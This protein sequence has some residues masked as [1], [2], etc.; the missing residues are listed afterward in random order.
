MV[1][2]S[3]RR[4]TTGAALGI[5]AALGVALLVVLAGAA[6]EAKEKKKEK[7]K[8][9]TVDEVMHKK[10]TGAM[11]H[12]QAEDYGA[13]AEILNPLAKRSEKLNPYERALVFQ[14]LGF[15]ESSQ[16][17][18][19]KALEYFEK[20]LAEDALP[21]GGQLS[22]RFNT[23][24]LYLATEQY[25]KAAKTLELWFEEAESPTSVAYYL[26]A[27]AYYQT[28]QIDRAISPAKQAVANSD[29]PKEPWLQLLAGLYFEKN[30]YANAL[31]PLKQLVVLYPKKS[32]WVQ[33]SALY[34]QLDREEEA[35]AALQL[36]YDQGFLDLDRELRQLA[37][38]Y[39]HHGLPYRAAFV[40]EKGLNDEVV[41]SDAESWE[42][43]ANSWLL[44]QESER[45][46]EPLAKAAQ[47]AESGDGFVRLGQVHLE[48]EEWDQ[49][50]AALA[51]G[52]E[53]GDLDDPGGV[54]LLLGIAFYHQNQLERARKH[55]G[56]ARS[57]ESSEKSARQWLELMDQESQSG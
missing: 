19:E 35:L 25:V 49:A 40:L 4:S 10:L 15:V 32:Y 11:E 45:A 36:A 51:T 42:M 18:Y 57:S 30:Q 14:I 29:E 47:L 12:L 43:L 8:Q 44:A 54:N 21:E 24:Q 1:E 9:Y 56:A 7:R 5:A 13:A 6:T 20:C 39:L 46:L 2:S 22:T 23:A 16:E 3:W 17:R 50:S 33:L 27:I 52:L 38:L 41:E 28:G 53:K 34:S 48:R 26:L 31:K 37:Q 55:F